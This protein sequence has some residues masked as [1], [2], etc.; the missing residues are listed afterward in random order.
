MPT[1][2]TTQ[3]TEVELT[4]K[5]RQELL[6]QFRQYQHLK[7]RADA[8][9]VQMEQ[10]KGKIA[11]IRDDLGVPSVGLEGFKTTLVAGT[12][13]AFDKEKFIDL[14]GDLSIYNRSMVT[15]PTKAYELV[16]VPDEKK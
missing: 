6:S 4:V 16:T 14:G 5:Q 10:V 9:K 13:E 11:G 15:R 8:I 3:T 2:T 1:I 12:R 7:Q